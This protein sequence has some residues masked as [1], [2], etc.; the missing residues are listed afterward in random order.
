MNEEPKILILE[1][2]PDDIHLLLREL[3]RQDLHFIKHVVSNKPDYI[4]ALREFRPDLILS[5]YSLPGFDGLTAY[6]IMREVLPDVPFIITSGAIGEENAIELIKA[7]VTDY[8][9]KDKLF[10][11]GSKIRRALKEA[12]EVR[13][14]KAESE[15]L[16]RQHQRLL[17]IAFL[18]S[19]QVRRPVATILGLLSLFTSGEPDNPLNAEVIERL[20]VAS[21]ELDAVVQEIV[22]KTN[23][24]NTQI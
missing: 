5:D 4:S 16:R 7:G 18:Q 24:I 8:A 19:H 9:L 17:E 23:E 3:E 20:K 6:H 2:N 14:K 11:L 12:E 10:V 15:R 13:L 1:D 21:K 22:R